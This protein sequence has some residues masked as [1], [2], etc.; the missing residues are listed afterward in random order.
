M[1]DNLGKITD[2]QYYLT[3]LA[4]SL[5]Q[6]LRDCTSILRY[7]YNVMFNTHRVRNSEFVVKR[8]FSMASY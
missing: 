3:L 2:I 1:P 6:W 7:M 4:V 5:Q 8:W